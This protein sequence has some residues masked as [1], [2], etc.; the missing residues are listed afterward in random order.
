MA[1]LVGNSVETVENLPIFPMW[2]TLP[3]NEKNRENSVIDGF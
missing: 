3:H 2:K 1:L